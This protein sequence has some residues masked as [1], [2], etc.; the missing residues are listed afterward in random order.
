[1]P[2]KRWLLREFW[3]DPD[4]SALPEQARTLYIAAG[5][6]A[7]D[8]GVL[9]R[10]PRIFRLLCWGYQAEV[11]SPEQ[12]E[13]WW[14]LLESEG[15]LIPFE[16]QGRPWV[17][18]K[19]TGWEA[20]QLPINRPSTRNP[21]PDWLTR[22]RTISYDSKGRP[23]SMRVNPDGFGDSS[24]P[25]DDASSN[26]VDAHA[27]PGTG[28][29]TGSGT[30]LIRSSSDLESSSD[31]ARDA[32]RLVEAQYARLV[33]RR[34][35]R[36]RGVDIPPMHLHRVEQA[37]ERLSVEDVGLLLRWAALDERG[38]FFEHT[39]SDPTLVLDLKHWHKRDG[40]L[41]RA[42]QWAAR[43]P[44]G[45]VSW[46]GDGLPAR[47]LRA[48]LRRITKERRS[49]ILEGYDGRTDYARI[50]DFLE[51]ETDEDAERVRHVNAVLAWSA[52]GD[53]DQDENPYETEVLTNP[54]CALNRDKW[55]RNLQRALEY[56]RR[57]K[58][59]K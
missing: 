18:I 17:A 45:G 4:L 10:D 41:T 19:P 28:S 43:Q 50:A 40:Y 54:T 15:F 20:S 12:V 38:P 42:E 31:R 16:A 35:L 36:R 58:A 2:R 7:D 51:G 25:A 14:K 6:E 47:L 26:A 1:M 49:E 46:E 22:R 9:R 44:N 33:E 34:G 56:K 5:G 29:G 32:L 52:L 39:L 59:G 24:P 21:A 55:D 11:P 37:F 8:N 57:R 23:T 13:A 30:G 27:P 53:R 48:E 3:T